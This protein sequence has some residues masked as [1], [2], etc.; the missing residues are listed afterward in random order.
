MRAWVIALVLLAVSIGAY[1][2]GDAVARGD[3]ELPGGAAAELDAE[4]GAAEPLRTDR[5]PTRPADE[6]GGRRGSTTPLTQPVTIAAENGVTRQ[7]LAGFTVTLSSGGADRPATTIDAERHTF[8]LAPGDYEVRGEKAGWIAP[9]AARF[10]I[11]AAPAP[12]P[13]II[14]LPFTRAGMRLALEVLDAATR[15]PIASYRATVQLFPAGQPR[16]TT[17]FLPD[18]RSQPLSVVGDPGQRVVVQIEAEGYRPAEPVEVVFD[19]AIPV[20]R[21]QVYLAR[22]MQFTGIE[23]QAADDALQPVR[24]LNVVAD[25]VRDDGKPGFLWNRTAAAEDGKYRLPDLGP[26]K[27]RF[28]LTSVDADDNPTLHVPRTVVVEYQDGQHIITPITFAAGA[29]I[30]LHATDTDGRTIG[31]DVRLELVF[32]DGEPRE[33]LWQPL[34]DGKPDQHAGLGADKL[35][36]DSKARLHRCVPPG[37]YTLRFAWARGTPVERALDL[38][39]GRRSPVEIRLSR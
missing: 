20:R 24:R 12:Q 34:T 5:V 31:T 9:A 32:P 6:P 7:P 25:R 11:H 19:A 18:Q 37:R 23:F 1:L 30:E 3:V 21:E 16:P 17:E 38:V 22:Q 36:R 26:G 13:I 4:P 35:V 10:T 2:L 39:A 14:R 33:T 15:Q 29:M 8:A 28:A 27:Y